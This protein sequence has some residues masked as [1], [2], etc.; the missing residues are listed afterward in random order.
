[1]MGIKHGAASASLIVQRKAGQ[2][3]SCTSYTVSHIQPPDPGGFHAFHLL[4]QHGVQGRVVHPGG[5]RGSQ[6]RLA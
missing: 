5:L 6:E 1:M 4:K 2:R 3:P